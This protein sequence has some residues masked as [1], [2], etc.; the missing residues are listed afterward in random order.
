MDLAINNLQ[1]LIC[2]KTQTTNKR[3]I[4]VG[5]LTRCALLHFKCDLKAAQING[6][7]SSLNQEIMLRKFELE[8]NALEANKNICW[9]KK[10]RLGCKNVDDTA[11]SDRPKIVDTE[12]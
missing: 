10:F 5:A 12:P 11:K 1:R 2:H 4:I 6:Q 3:I 8:H 9:F 7:L